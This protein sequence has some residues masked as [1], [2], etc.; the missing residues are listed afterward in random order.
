MNLQTRKLSLIEW[1]VSLNDKATIDRIED[2]KKG[3]KAKREM[4]PMSLKEYYKIIKESEEDIQYGRVYAHEE[5]VK[6][7]KRKR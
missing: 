1:M 6:Y 5:V 7:L 3:K 4:K 2:L